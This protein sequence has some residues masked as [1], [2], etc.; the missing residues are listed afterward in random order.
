MQ[1]V[2]YKGQSGLRGPSPAIWSHLGDFAAKQRGEG[3]IAH[4]DDF[5]NLPVLSTSANTGLYASFV[6]TSCTLT[7]V[8]AAWGVAKFLFDGT[9]ADTVALQVGGNSGSSVAADSAANYG[10]GFEIRIKKSSITNND[11]GFFV[12]F[13][14]EGTAVDNTL[15]DTTGALVDADFLGFHCTMAAAATVNFV[16]RKTGAAATT[17]ISGVQTMVADTYY[18]FGFLLLPGGYAGKSSTRLRVAVDGV[19]SG[20]FGTDATLA[21]STFPTANMSPLIYIKNGSG[22]NAQTSHV[23]WMRWSYSDRI[24]Q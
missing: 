1:L 17:L 21:L 4:H 6:D 14:S 22:S 24:G 18:K 8:D 13:A 9:A 15:V 19:E 10:I 3:G 23:D 7:Q 5:I 11:C 20:T 2:T 12:G 16:H